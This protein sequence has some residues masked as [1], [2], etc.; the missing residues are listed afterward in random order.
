M[1]RHVSGSSTRHKGEVRGGRV[2][3]LR[4][5]GLCTLELCTMSPKKIRA[6]ARRYSSIFFRSILDAL[7]EDEYDKLYRSPIDNRHTY[8][9][10]D[11]GN[12]K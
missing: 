7:R 4:S 2:E 8:Y 5:R 6:S 3:G 1:A 9:Y 11:E 12:L 10:F